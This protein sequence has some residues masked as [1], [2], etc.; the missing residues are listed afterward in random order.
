MS[1][2]AHRLMVTSSLRGKFGLKLL[3]SVE[4]VKNSVFTDLTECILYYGMAVRL[5]GPEVE[6]G[7][8][9]W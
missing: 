7:F 9:L 1:M 2:G 4:T 5:W 8:D 6:E 3:N